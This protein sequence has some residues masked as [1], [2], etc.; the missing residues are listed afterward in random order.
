MRVASAARAPPDDSA[1]RVPMTP[2]PTSVPT[3]QHTSATVTATWR[4]RS[5]GWTPVLVRVVIGPF[6]HGHG[7]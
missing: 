6:H 4:R 7:R 5:E 1:T 3:T 2:T